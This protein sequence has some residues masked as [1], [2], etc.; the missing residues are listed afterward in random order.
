MRAVNILGRVL[1]FIASIIIM[2]SVFVTTIEIKFLKISLY[3]MSLYEY[4]RVGSVVIIILA[5]LC[6]V[7]VYFNRGFLASILSIIIL[8]MDFYTASTLN[9]GS[10]EIDNTMNKISFLF[11]N[12]FSP[13]AGFI[14]I[15]LGAV[16]LFFSG[17]MIRKSRETMKE[18]ENVSKDKETS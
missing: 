14:L 9:T 18:K 17:I 15:V 10:S 6:A 3:S 5:L 1:G 8:V 2:I 4:N 7:A 16:V 11:G 13:E 12:I